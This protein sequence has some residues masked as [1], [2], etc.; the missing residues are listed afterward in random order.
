ML[1]DIGTVNIV[2]FTATSETKLFISKK[3]ILNNPERI[4]P[5]V[6]IFLSGI[7]IRP[8]LKDQ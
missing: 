6:T 5:K 1:L 2:E 3:I 4:S 8:L 7:H